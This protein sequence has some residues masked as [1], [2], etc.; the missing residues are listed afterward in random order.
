MGWLDEDEKTSRINKEEKELKKTLDTMRE[1]LLNTPGLMFD[2]E[3]L[4]EETIAEVLKEIE[5]QEILIKAI[6]QKYTPKKYR[7]K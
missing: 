5:R 4:H 1:Q 7:K 6:N 3:P 2:G